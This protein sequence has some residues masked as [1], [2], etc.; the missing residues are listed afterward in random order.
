MDFHA[1]SQKDYE[2]WRK[3]KVSYLEKVCHANLSKLSYILREISHRG[4]ER[5]DYQA[6]LYEI[7]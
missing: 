4:K 6:S 3:G 7:S 1:L 5:K 2:D